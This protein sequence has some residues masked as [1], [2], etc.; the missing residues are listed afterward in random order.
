M[1]SQNKRRVEKTISAKQINCTHELGKHTH[2]TV[3][4]EI[5]VHRF[6]LD[7]ESVPI[8]SLPRFLNEHFS[9]I[10]PIDYSQGAHECQL[11]PC[12]NDVSLCCLLGILKFCALL[13]VSTL[14]SAFQCE[15]HGR[16]SLV[17]GRK[18]LFASLS[19]GK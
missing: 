3:E 15:A 4:F 13:I 16:N 19:R 9:L 12:F 18:C 7:Q 2:R 1:V 10:L 14:N 11:G 17:F 8:D 6:T 5:H